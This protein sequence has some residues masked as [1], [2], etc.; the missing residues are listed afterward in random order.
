MSVSGTWIR[1]LLLA[2]A[3]AL[4]LG[5]RPAAGGSAAQAS[6]YW[7]VFEG[8]L[9]NNYRPYAIRPDGSRLTPLLALNRPMVPFDVSR[10]GRTIAYFGDSATAIYVSRG[11]GTGLHRIARARGRPWLWDAALSPD[12][13]M[14]AYSTD[15][16][17]PLAVVGTNGRGRRELGSARAADID[18]SPDGRALVYKI[19]KSFEST[20]FVQPLRGK[21]RVLGRNATDPTWSPT[22]R[23]IAYGTEKG[24]ITL[25]QPDGGSRHRLRL[26]GPFAWSPGGRILAGTV[27]Q[28]IVLARV[29]GRIVRRIRLRG[30]LNTSRLAWAPGGRTLLVE[31]SEPYQIW[32][33]GADGRG[34]HRVTRLGNSRLVGWT[35]LAPTQPSVPSLLPTERV[36]GPTTV[37][38]RSPLTDLSAD[39]ERVAFVVAA[40]AADCQHLTV[41]TPA[42]R[43]LGRSRGP[44]PC[45]E[46]PPHGGIYDVELA[47][48]RVTWASETD[49]GNTCTNTLES[50]E[51]GARS[52]QMVA[53]AGGD[54]DDPFDFHVRGHGNLLVFN[55]KDGSRLV[56][57]GSGRE[58]CQEGGRLAAICTTL[59]RGAHSGLVDSVSGGFIAVREDQAAAVLDEHGKLLRVV[60]LGAGEVSAARLDGGRLVVS[61]AG[62][63]EVYDVSTGAGVLQRPL[64]AHF[65][66]V[67]VDGGIAV[68]RRDNAVMLLR[69][70]DRRSLTLTPGRSV[71]AALEAPGLYYSYA[72]GDG[73]GQVAFMPRVDILQKLGG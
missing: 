6:G 67:D 9:D 71:R 11:N 58:R 33:V 48:S 68:L 45:A 44:A 31:R 2:L 29:D 27:S 19:G 28:G 63:I 65:R 57:I 42:T 56:R 39:G 8:D 22:G 23:W 60:P 20:L 52:R 26:R 61:H 46:W 32:A 36:T 41:W 10:D 17:K 50:I 43:A 70:E 51:L 47:G 62:A 38:T 40:T 35:R 21:R 53:L 49:C 66:L 25:V 7:I 15:S 69:L 5:G 54:D 4:A 37:A 73:G 55:L 64:P 12:G 30:V 14:V 3:A 59:R 34:L 72:T 13:R 1:V 16:R 24:V 18:W